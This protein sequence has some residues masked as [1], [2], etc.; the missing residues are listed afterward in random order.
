MAWLITERSRVA[1]LVLPRYAA[2]QAVAEPGLVAATNDDTALA[3]QAVPAGRRAT[4]TA[5]RTARTSG[6]PGVRLRCDL[7]LGQ[8]RTTVGGPEPT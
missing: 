6:E 2:W 4:A 7:V 8:E 1:G 3:S 5:D